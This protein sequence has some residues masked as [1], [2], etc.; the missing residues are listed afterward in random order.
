MYKSVE[1]KTRN[2]QRVILHILLIFRKKKSSLPFSCLEERFQTKESPFTDPATP[3]P[4][5]PFLHFAPQ[6]DRD[7]TRCVDH[8]RRQQSWTESDIL[9]WKRIG[10]RAPLTDDVAC[11]LSSERIDH[12]SPPLSIVALVVLSWSDIGPSRSIDAARV[13]TPRSSFLEVAPIRSK[14]RARGGSFP[15]FSSFSLVFRSRNCIIWSGYWT[16]E[17]HGLLKRKRTVEF[18]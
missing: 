2:I 14:S 12:H 18:E 9:G 4:A 17:W 15:S 6:S 11:R 7:R 8:I 1:K 13:F 5:T 10:S 3:I 16:S